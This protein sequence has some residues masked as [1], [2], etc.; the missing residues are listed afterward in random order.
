MRHS[1]TQ[2]VDTLDDRLLSKLPNVEPDGGGDRRAT[3]GLAP[4]TDDDMDMFGSEEV[5]LDV[6]KPAGVV[7]QAIAQASTPVPKA[8]TTLEHYFLGSWIG[9]RAIEKE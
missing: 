6:A 3:P 1:L 9:C 8:V 5:A 2:C 7:Q 4:S